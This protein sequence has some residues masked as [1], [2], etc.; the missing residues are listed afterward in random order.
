MTVSLSNSLVGLTL[1][2]GTNSF[3][4]FGAGTTATDSIAVRIARAGFTLP[5]T[6]PP[7]KETSSATTSESSQIAA[8]KRMASL[9]DRAPTG[10]DA[11]P[12]D[13]ETSFTTYKALD[14]LRVLA[15]SAARPTTGSAERTRLND[16]FARGMDELQTYL[17]QARSDRLD[18]TFGVPTRRAETVGVAATTGFEVKGKGVLATRDAPIPGV[19]GTEI[20][21]ITLDKGAGITDTVRVDL[22]SGA[23]PPTLDS[24]ADQ[25]NAAI[26]AIP[27]R[28]PD[29]SVVVDANGQTQPRWLV[30]FVPDKSTD[31]WGFALKNPALENVSISQDNAADAVMVAAA[32]TPLD[33]PGR[34]R[35]MRIDDPASGGARVSLGDIAGYD[36][37]A[38]ERAKLAAPTR[39]APAGVTLSTPRIDA[40]TSAD[41]MATAPDGSTYVLGTTAGE[42]GANRPAGTQDLFLTKTDSEG[43]VLWQR[44]LGAS[45]SASG[46]AITLAANG[47][48][49]VAGTVTGGF[50]GQDSDGDMLVARFDAAGEEQ[51]ATLVR[52][53]GVDRASAIATGPDGSIYVGGT[54]GE[55][56]GDAVIARLDAQGRVNERRTLGGAGTQ[57]IAALAVAPDGSLLALAS[58][59]GT[60]SVRRF[61]A[62]AL[63]TDLGE[64]SLGT[65]D[66]R[67]LAVDADGAIA[68][69]GA[70]LGALNGSAV[71]SPS[72]ARDGFVARIE[73]NLGAARISYIGSAG[74][75]EVDSIAFMNGRLYAGGRTTGAIGAA[76]TGATDGFVVAL[77]PAS[78]AQVSATQFG[79]VAQRTEPVRISAAPG[80]ASALGALGLARGML[81]PL[82]GQSLVAQTSLRAG[83]SFSVR[84]QGGAVRKITIA[85][86][87]SM[88]TLADKVRRALGTGASVTTPTVDGR[89]TLRIEARTGSDIDLIAGPDGTDALARLGLSPTRLSVPEIAGKRD[90]AVRPGG[91]YGLALT[92]ALSLDSAKDAAIA[93]TKIREAI[94]TTQTAYRSLYWDDGKAALVN[95][96]TT[97]GSV[98]ASQ[99]AQ[100]A[101]YQAALDRISAFTGI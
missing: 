80:G 5:E 99:A 84:A 6:T 59:A 23:Q 11:L 82:D 54:A 65:A 98:S 63:T 32:Q 90:P 3:A 30:R 60:A 7:W 67:A 39:T 87:D 16:L 22:S 93:A 45:Q 58:D 49:V 44:M 36:R 26:T 14:R 74:T 94:S 52:S 95:A 53:I 24:I 50:D 83:D 100:A 10:L 91:T 8:I 76:R 12:A 77:D 72:G 19:A 89:K 35:L 48:V 96:R 70:T 21:T 20:F 101:R 75:D 13:V 37:L 17:G 86:D 42:L 71:N 31:K 15:E 18:L 55:F 28:N 41:A 57:G 68:V 88:T 4:S 92:P 9:I 78:G 34:V 56:S 51:F 27:L 85:D 25:I 29:G 46:A 69:G 81:T 47:D 66:A 2:S 79:S 38:T 40:V 97:G 62:Q 1:L 73:P 64:I 61:D 43:R 33:A